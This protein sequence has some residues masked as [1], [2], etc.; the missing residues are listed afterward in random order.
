MP[1]LLAFGIFD[2]T[3]TILFLSLRGKST[4]KTSRTGYAGA[5]AAAGEQER[6]VLPFHALVEL[7][8]SGDEHFD[9]LMMAR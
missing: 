2:I 5:A 1:A 8:T 3:I 7:R 6:I 9:D 4:A